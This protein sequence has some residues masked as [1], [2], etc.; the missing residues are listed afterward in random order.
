MFFANFVLM[1]MEVWIKMVFL[2]WLHLNGLE[3]GLD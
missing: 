1:D 2:D 3:C